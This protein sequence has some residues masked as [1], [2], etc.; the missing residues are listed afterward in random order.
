MITMS[1]E[2][3]SCQ[4]VFPNFTFTT[5]SFSS[6]VAN[7]RFSDAND[8][9]NPPLWWRERLVDHQLASTH[10]SPRRVL[11]WFFEFELF[12]MRRTRHQKNHDK[13]LKK[14]QI[15]FIFQLYENHITL[16]IHHPQLEPF[17][18]ERIAPTKKNSTTWKVFTIS[19]NIVSDNNIFSGIWK[20]NS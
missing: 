15:P 1:P 5:S 18:F 6:P 8:S 10:Y 2:R 14:K 7:M 9:Q 12:F 13:L 17:F 4:A 16:V 3:G 19:H 11:L 20:W